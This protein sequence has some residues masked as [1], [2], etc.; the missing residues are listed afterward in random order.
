MFKL[1]LS[2]AYFAPVAIDM[3]DADGVL[4]T[5]RF[6]ARFKRL[7][8]PTVVDIQKR[9]EAKTITDGQL[10]DEIMI[11]WRGIEDA[12]GNPL[13]FTADEVRS[14]CTK[15]SGLRQAIVNAWFASL[16]P[17]ESAVL[18]EKN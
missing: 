11:G 7:D 15:V 9:A 13:A 17:R 12:D 1:D 8:E 14:V 4:R 16:M 6:D 10:L 5:H 2:P 18:A 3:L